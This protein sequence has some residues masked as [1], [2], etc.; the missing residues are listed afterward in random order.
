MGETGDVNVNTLVPIC[1]VC[2]F[3]VSLV[4]DC[5]SCMG[6][7]S[8][9]TLCCFSAKQVLCKPSVEPGSY[10]KMCFIECDIDPFTTFLSSRSQCLILD[11][12][13]ALPNNEKVPCICNALG[14]TV[15]FNMGS[16]CRC[17][18]TI[19]DMK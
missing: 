12:R 5:S 13:I 2:C 18:N 4:P 1:G 8:E 11:C 6:C 3:I 16:R 14:L 17:F 10:C 19:G 9:S 7:V 15:C